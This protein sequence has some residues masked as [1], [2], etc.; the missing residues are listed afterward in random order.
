MIAKIRIYEPDNCLKKGY[1]SIFKEII[2]EI[3]DNKWL[4]YQLFKRD[5]SSMYRESFFGVLWI[6]IIPLISIAGF[7][8]LGKSNVVNIGLMPVSFPIYAISGL[9]IWQLFSVGMIASTNSL[10]RAGSMVVKINVSKKSLIISA[11]AQ[12]F[13][14]FVVLLLISFILVL[15][16][17]IKLTPAILLF[18]FLILP[19]IFFTIG[20]GFFFALVNGIFRDVGN[21]ISVIVTFIMLFTPILYAVPESGAFR[22]MV[23]YNPLYYMISIPREVILTGRLEHMYG[24]IATSIVAITVFVISLVVFHVTEARIAERI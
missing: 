14:P 11:Y 13:F 23:K 15:L 19:I 21:A 3:I 24:F 12:S 4:I 10:V 9:S 22:I 18:P 5:F 6:I 20:L 1:L 7:F 2:D 16:S 17:G 8:L